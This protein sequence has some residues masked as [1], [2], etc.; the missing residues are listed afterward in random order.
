MQ[1]P[2]PTVDSL[3]LSR[4]P[5]RS[6]QSCPAMEVVHPGFSTFPMRGS[7]KNVNCAVYNS[8]IIRGDKRKRSKMGGEAIPRQD[9]AVASKLACGIIVS[10]ELIFL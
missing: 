1:G 4:H 9:T 5:W 10:Y 6:D 8:S 2:A 3:Q 7:A